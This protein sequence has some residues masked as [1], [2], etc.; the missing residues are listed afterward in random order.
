MQLSPLSVW[1]ASLWLTMVTGATP[2][3]S[4]SIRDMVA[5]EDSEVA[6]VCI[7]IYTYTW[8]SVWRP[9]ACYREYTCICFGI[10]KILIST[11]IFEPRH[12]K[13]NKV[14]VR[15]AKTQIRL[16]IPSRI[17]VFAVRLMGSEGYPSFY[18]DSE[19][20]DQT[21]RMPRLI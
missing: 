9:S 16:G 20:S 5:K 1:S 2:A 18:A 12:D 10:W 17:R 7:F 21:G 14:T 3:T 4:R 15:S 11:F 13:A 19:D 8:S 6:V